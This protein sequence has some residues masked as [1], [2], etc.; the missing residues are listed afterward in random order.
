MK[1]CC[2]QFK[3]WS[4][5]GTASFMDATQ[6]N[7]IWPIGLVSAGT[8]YT[9]RIGSRVSWDW[10]HLRGAMNFLAPAG[11]AAGQAYI[12]RLAIVYDRQPTG[13]RPLMSDIYSLHPGSSDTLD[14][15]TVENMDRFLI[16]KEKFWV[17]PGN[18]GATWA[19]PSF[20][21]PWATVPMGSD[22]MVDWKIDL[23]GLETIFGGGIDGN[24]NN[25]RSGQFYMVRWCNNSISTTGNPC[26][27]T[28]AC[29]MK[30]SDL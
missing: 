27:I 15:A 7:C 12:I 17:F 16:L 1:R 23:K 13:G 18:S 11:S 24:E 10:L 2:E 8:A 29:R 6:A 26:I 30:F 9:D 28:Y 14:F 25:T 21:P 20:V 5:G 3:C 4:E 22:M 19:T